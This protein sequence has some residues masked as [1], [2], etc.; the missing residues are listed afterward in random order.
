MIADHAR[1]MAAGEASLAQ[2]KSA[3]E[4]ASRLLSAPGQDNSGSSE[5]SS[6]WKLNLLSIA[7]PFP[8]T[9]YKYYA[10]TI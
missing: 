4:A 8:A 1:V 2:A 9:T 6:L 3:T 5:V 10:S 7:M